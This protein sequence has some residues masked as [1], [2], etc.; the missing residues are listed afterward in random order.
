MGFVSDPRGNLLLPAG[1][2]SELQSNFR[3]FKTYIY[4]SGWLHKL[5][6]WLVSLHNWVILDLGSYEGEFRT[7]IINIETSIPDW[8][9]DFGDAMFKTFKE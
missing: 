2:I 7:K 3:A 9:C 1:K 4:N 6:E 8:F 5:L